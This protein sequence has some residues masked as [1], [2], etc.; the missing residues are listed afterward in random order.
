MG[1]LTREFLI[2]FETNLRSIVESSY[3]GFSSN[4]WWD[5]YMKR[6]GTG[7]RKETVAWL[8]STAMIHEI[9]KT[10]GEMVFEDLVQTY[11]EYEMKAAAAGL[12]MER[13]KLEDLDGGGVD[14]AGKWAQDIGAYMAYW[15]Q[16]KLAELINGGEAATAKSYDNVPFF[17][18]A[19]PINPGDTSLGTFANIFTGA[20]AST[21]STDPNDANYPGALVIDDSVTVD[22]A[23]QNLAK[24]V[25]YIRG[26]RM[27]NGKD[28]RFLRPVGLI[29]PPRM[30]YRAAELSG[31]KFIASGNGTTD[32]EA[33]I[34]KFGFAEPVVAD[35]LAGAFGGSDTSWYLAC[36]EIGGNGSQI[37]SF[38]YLDR[39]P[40]KV[41]YYTGQGGGTG[42][43]AVLDRADELEW[44]CKGR[45]SASYGHP[46]T[47]FKGKAA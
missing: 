29:V 16:K 2:D 39:E 22:V 3:A 4:L 1:A 30:A 19:H 33:R 9:N 14:L 27:P 11:A 7:S 18:N 36:E 41:T 8:L 37:G 15:P 20:A 44:H 5:R 23:L 10:G 12:K 35:E 34:A 28:P 47:F 21:P 17:S 40:F 13:F 32:V 38:L 45:F 6:R 42:V 46:F 24:A 31:A 43:D 26:I 25:A